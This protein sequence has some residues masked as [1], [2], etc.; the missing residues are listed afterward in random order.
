MFR[1]CSASVLAMAVLWGLVLAVAPPAVA[2]DATSIEAETMSLSTTKGA[3]II[4]D[5][6]ASGATALSL[7]G[8]VTLSTT[9]ALPQ[10]V[11]VV[12]RAKGLQ[13]LVRPSPRC[14][15]TVL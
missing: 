2:A 15:S 11:K 6:G 1:C 3:K 9:L 12:M 13:C 4:A 5:A 8:A 7:T 14:P 10:S